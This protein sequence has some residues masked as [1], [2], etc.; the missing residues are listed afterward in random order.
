MDD[1]I[2]NTWYLWESTTWSR[3]SHKTLET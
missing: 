1:H 2:R 3:Q